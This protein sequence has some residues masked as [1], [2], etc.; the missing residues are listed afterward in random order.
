MDVMNKETVER[1]CAAL[2]RYYRFN[3]VRISPPTLRNQEEQDEHLRLLLP[4]FREHLPQKLVDEAFDRVPTT[5]PPQYLRNAMASCLACRVVYKEGECRF[6]PGRG[7]GKGVWQCDAC[8]SYATVAHGC[9]SRWRR[10]G[11]I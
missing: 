6:T 9:V 2:S 3:G 10:E 4:L 7:G 11:G 8:R 5:L 1:T